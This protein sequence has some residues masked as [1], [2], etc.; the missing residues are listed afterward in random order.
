MALWVKFEGLREQLDGRIVIFS[1]E[2]FVSLS[3]EFIGLGK[4]Y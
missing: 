3:L 1:L 2:G 4:F